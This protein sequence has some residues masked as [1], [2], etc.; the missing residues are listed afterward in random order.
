MVVGLAAFC[1]YRMNAIKKSYHS[2]RKT[3]QSQISHMDG[4]SNACRGTLF[5]ELNVKDSKLFV[6][7]I[8]LLK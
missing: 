1:F 3:S 8:N 5:K 4:K 6:L 2:I 7:I